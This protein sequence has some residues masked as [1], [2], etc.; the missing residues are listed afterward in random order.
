[1]A[2]S[3]RRNHVN[4]E[5]LASLIQIPIEEYNERVREVVERFMSPLPQ[6][7]MT[8][9]QYM[10]EFD[11]ADNSK[12]RELE[13]QLVI[14]A[15]GLAAE[16]GEVANLANKVNQQGYEVDEE[17][18]D[19]LIKEAGDVIWYLAKLFKHVLRIS[20]SEAMEKNI[21]KLKR[22]FPDGFSLE[23]SKNRE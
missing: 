11:F 8:W 23:K 3:V 15:T 20:P 12:G 16:A 10:E 1:D 21:D 17:M 4:W 5:F 14:A 7:P 9:R 2:A 19:A 13:D 22:R 6:E 18:R